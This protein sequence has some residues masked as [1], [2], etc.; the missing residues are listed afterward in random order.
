[1][2]DRLREGM[3]VRTAEGDKLGKIASIRDD[4]FIIEKGWLFKEDYIARFD[5]VLDVQGDEVIYRR[6]GEAE[7]A[8]PPAERAT[9]AEPAAATG[10]EPAAATGT[11]PAAAAGTEEMRLPLAEEQL[12]AE[13]RAREAGEVQVRKEVTTHEEQIAVPV[14][15][16][17]VTVERVPA[18]GQ[19]APEATFQREAVSVPV[20][21]EEVEVHKRPVVREEVVVQ[22]APVEEQRVAAA[23][24]RREE[25]VVEDETIRRR[26][27]DKDKYET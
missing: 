12:V 27:E 2:R 6:V 5:Q 10:A 25:A 15:H 26:A 4:G 16:E 23:E 21:E 7:A 24:V 18:S 22:R 20:M 1:M 13:K 8:P 9:G 11:E 3:T 17:E 14:Q 19:P